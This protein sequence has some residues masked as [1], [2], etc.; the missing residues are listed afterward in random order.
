MTARIRLRLILALAGSFLATDVARSQALLRVIPFYPPSCPA[1][2][3][4]SWCDRLLPPRIRLGGDVD[5]DGVPDVVGWNCDLRCFSGRTGDCLLVFT[6][7]GFSGILD[8]VGDWDGDGFPDPVLADPGGANR[9]IVSGVSGAVLLPIVPPPGPGSVYSVIDDLDADGVR[10]FAWWNGTTLFVQSSRAGLLLRVFPNVVGPGVRGIGD[11]DGDGLPDLFQGE[12]IWSGPGWQVN[13][14]AVPTGNWDGGAFPVGDLDADGFDD[15]A[16]FTESPTEST[17]TFR[18]GP[19]TSQ[20]PESIVLEMGLECWAPIGP[21]LGDVDG[22]GRADC[23][24]RGHDTCGQWPQ[25]EFDARVLAVTGAGN[26]F[27]IQVPPAGIT[28]GGFGWEL[29]AIGDIDGDKCT[30]WATSGGLSI[31][32]GLPISLSQVQISLWSARPRLAFNVRQLAAPGLQLLVSASGLEAGSTYRMFF[33]PRTVYG[34]C[35]PGQSFAGLDHLCETSHL[36]QQLALPL[37]SPPFHFQATGEVME[38]GP[39]AWPFTGQSNID[40][41]IIDLTAGEYRGWTPW[42]FWQ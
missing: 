12:S 39:V 3:A 31:N 1:P 14:G 16:V 37:G 36:Y 41:L 38:F 28:P 5:A 8:V 34:T 2:A 21:P 18:L 19:S 33:N 30:D 23:M 4:T 25:S 26:L 11:F 6:P 20:T 29:E 35:Y 32:T 9:R 27:T 40:G 15:V 42:V 17:W 13:L 7:P 10:D 24:Y 22:D